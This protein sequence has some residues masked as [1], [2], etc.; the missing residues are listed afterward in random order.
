MRILALFLMVLLFGCI[1]TPVQDINENPEDY[2][3]EEVHVQGTVHNTLK[4]GKLSGFTLKDGNHSIKVSSEEL[5]KEGKEVVV[6]GTVM[7]DTLFGYYIL[8]KEIN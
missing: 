2:V 5:P 7:K 6:K 3:G 1:G 8:A 4:F